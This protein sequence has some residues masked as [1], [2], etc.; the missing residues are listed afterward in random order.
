MIQIR[1][2]DNLRATFPCRLH[3]SLVE[4]RVLGSDHKNGSVLAPGH[5][6][7]NASHEVG[8]VSQT[9]SARASRRRS[10]TIIAM[11]AVPA[12]VPIKVICS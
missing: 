3:M 9:K 8:R 2:D 6:L 10:G 4:V 1:H 12:D 11:A 5:A 7:C